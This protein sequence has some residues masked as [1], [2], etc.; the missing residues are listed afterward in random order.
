MATYTS[1]GI[2]QISASCVA[3]SDASVRDAGG[4]T[5]AGAGADAGEHPSQ[6]WRR[7]GRD[8]QDP[9]DGD[10][11]VAMMDAAVRRSWL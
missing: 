4:V 6:G 2:H 10:E 1:P 7:C 8:R 9:G 5:A 3:L 11:G